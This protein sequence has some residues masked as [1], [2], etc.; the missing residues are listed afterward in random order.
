L[1]FAVN[2]RSCPDSPK[3]LSS[4]WKRAKP[5]SSHKTQENLGA[6]IAAGN[7][8]QLAK[9]ETEGLKRRAAQRR[10][11]FFLTND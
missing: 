10:S 5:R 7:S 9:I 6:K 1:S 2:D 4:P 8:T 11:L 3:F